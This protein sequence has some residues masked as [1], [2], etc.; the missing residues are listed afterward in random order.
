[1]CDHYSEVAPR[2]PPFLPLTCLNV[3]DTSELTFH[4]PAENMSVMNQGDTDEDS[5][6]VR[7]P[8][9]PRCLK[10]RITL[11]MSP[12]WGIQTSMSA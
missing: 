3:S 9:S 6:T 5:S 1:M 10:Y 4:L 7:F 11:C 8:H 12:G 2:S